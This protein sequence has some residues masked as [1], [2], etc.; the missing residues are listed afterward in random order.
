MSLINFFFLI[1]GKSSHTTPRPV[2]DPLASHNGTACQPNTYTRVHGQTAAN[3]QHCVWEHNGCA[4]PVCTAHPPKTENVTLSQMHPTTPVRAFKPQD[5]NPSCVWQDQL[6]TSWQGTHSACSPSHP[7]PYAYPPPPPPCPS[8]SAKSMSPMDQEPAP[9]IASAS[10]GSMQ[11]QKLL[12]LSDAELELIRQLRQH[13]VKVVRTV[14]FF[15][16]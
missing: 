10:S 1:T 11:Q 3:Y 13:G 9:S 15:F 6:P 4:V 7:W 8:C 2:Y 16:S 14:V 12:W 5:P